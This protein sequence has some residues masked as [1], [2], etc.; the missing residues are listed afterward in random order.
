MNTLTNT[1]TN[2]QEVNK[3]NVISDIEMRIRYIATIFRLKKIKVIGKLKLFASIDDDT[4]ILVDE[5]QKGILIK[6]LPPI[7][8]KVSNREIKIGRIIKDK[9]HYNKQLVIRY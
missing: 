9:F 5:I 6:E 2:L 1:V 4:I 7:Y 8:Y 3:M